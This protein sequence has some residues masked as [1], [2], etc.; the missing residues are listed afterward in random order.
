MARPTKDGLDYFPLDVDMD[1]DDKVL[2]IISKFGFEG[3]GILVKLLME[4]YKN[5]YFYKWTEK[6]QI[7]FSSRVSVDINLVKEIVEECVKWGLFD[8]KIYD[9]KHILTSKGIQ[10]RFLLATSRRV[11]VNINE[12]LR[13][14]SVDINS[15]SNKKKSSKSTQS[16]VKE[17]KENKSKESEEEEKDAAV[18]F[19][20]N[21]APISSVVVQ[22][23]EDWENDFPS[24]V[25][26]R[27]M[28][29]AIFQNARNWKYINNTLKNWRSN[30]AKNLNDVEHLI[31]EFERK[32]NKTI[33]F[34]PKNESRYGNSW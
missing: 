2:I 28:E 32:K 22:Q 17:S 8:Q 3:F 18:F 10:E 5:G 31:R 19:D 15:N 1:Q 7:I 4:I 11:N 27:A 14:V 20:E 26:I 30:G 34:K 16:K 25:I 6:E 21:I 9:E 13:L 23:I 33:P 12:E 29:E 24:E